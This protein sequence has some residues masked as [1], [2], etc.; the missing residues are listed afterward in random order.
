M[1][2]LT[3]NKKLISNY[4]QVLLNQTL[5][6]SFNSISKDFYQNLI[7][8]SESRKEITLFIIKEELNLLRSVFISSPKF[9]FFLNNPTYNENLK[10]LFLIKI[11]PGLS[12]LTKIFLKLLV[13]KNHLYLLPFISEEFNKLVF[14]NQKKLTVKLIT[15]S[16][17]D[18][19]LGKSLLI[20]L[21]K[22]T[23]A[24]E[25][26]LNIEYNPK[27]LGGFIIEYNSISIDTSLVQEFNN[28]LNNI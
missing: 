4:S 13:E 20:N 18:K 12:N 7:N 25:I 10:L 2:N 17:L 16:E 26:L 23:T 3:I 19:N 8:N 6:N 27:L 22:I 24:K 1:T 28:F 14:L 11:F 9:L 21:R 5:S 15:A